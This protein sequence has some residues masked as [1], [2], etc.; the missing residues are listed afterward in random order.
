MARSKILS[1]ICELPLRTT[2][3]DERELS[4]RLEV[5]RQIYN[6]C[7]GESFKRLNLMRE[8]KDW[9]LAR[10]M[11]KGED[12]T[13]LFKVITKRFDFSEYSI[14]TFSSECRKENHSIKDHI[15]SHEARAIA[16]R[17]F[18]AVKQYSFGGRGRPSFK[19]FRKL[20]S[21]E[22]QDESGILWKRDHIKWSGGFSIPVILDQKNA[23][24]AKALQCPTKYCRVIRKTI[25]GKDRW[26]VQLI[27]EGISP[28]KVKNKI[29]NEVVGLD[30]GPSTIA[31]VGESATS[32]QKLCPTIEQPWKEIKNIQRAMG[33]S[34]RTTNPT[35][36]NEDGTIKKGSNKWIKSRHYKNLQKRLA[37]KERKLAAERKRSHGELANQIL[38]SGNIIKTEKL[39]YQTFQKN[40]GKSVQVRAPG[41][42]VELLRRKAKASGGK[43]EEFSTQTTRLSQT[44]HS[45]G[46]IKK[47]P[48][49]LRVHQCECGLGPVQRDL[50][51]AFLAR[52]VRGN[53]LDASQAVEAWPSAEP[54]LEQAASS[55]NQSASRK[56][57]PDPYALKGVRADRLLKE[58]EVINEV[59]DGV[60][61]SKGI[62][63]GQEEL[64]NELSKTSNK[65]VH[66][67]AVRAQK[68]QNDLI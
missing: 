6:A 9:Q 5:A 42:L 13:D 51:S 34:Q 62:C 29:G 68:I 3:S 33:R 28:S 17:A 50:Y 35:N 61:V 24:Q 58:A 64:I 43:L 12:R 44:C 37:E 30:I 36:Y 18:D 26:F 59:L 57:I 14:Y 48:L 40:F 49:S 55:F 31:I 54:L 46:T 20:V 4:I 1:F 45:C 19:G 8:S 38:S 60:A 32:L 52:F 21:V 22:G 25:K 39:S 16:K 2:P 7:L 27:Q 56:G 63:E 67:K 11:P 41:M 23:W 65:L 53:K 10:A 15:S 66:A 47:K